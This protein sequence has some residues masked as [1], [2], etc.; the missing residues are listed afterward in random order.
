MRSGGG[1][2]G[3]LSR[4][5]RFDARAPTSGFRVVLSESPSFPSVWANACRFQKEVGVERPPTAFAVCA[6]RVSVSPSQLSRAKGHRARAVDVPGICR[7][8]PSHLAWPSPWSGG[9][10][11]HDRNL[12]GRMWDAFELS[13]G[14]KN[15]SH[16]NGGC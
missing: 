15:A 13:G 9:R 14:A 16:D 11:A 3:L 12:F 1:L 5:A 7:A 4:P 6:G 8:A 2:L 10:R